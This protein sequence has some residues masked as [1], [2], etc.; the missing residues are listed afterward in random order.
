MIY[1]RI[2]PQSAL[3]DF[4]KEH[5]L[6]HF[7]YDHTKPIMVK[8]FPPI[9]E[10]GIEFFPKGLVTSFNYNTGVL[11]EEPRNAIFGQ[12]VS[13]INFTMPAEDYIMIRVIFK[14]G[15]LYRLLGIPLTSFTDIKTDA[16]CVI[17]RE[18][19]FVNEQ[20]AE[21][22][23]YQTMIE[24]VEKYL[25]VKIRKLKTCLHPVDKAG[26][27]ILADPT[28]F[29]LDW[30]SNQSCLSPRQFQ[31]KFKERMGVGPKLL[32]RIARFHGAFLYKETNPHADWLTVAV[33]FGYTDFHHLFKD[34]GEF[35][36]AT[37]NILLKQYAQSPE[38]ILKLV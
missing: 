10:H 34:F 35:A 3:Q 23:D 9:P 6:L 5:M 21:T 1:K 36:Q 38:K 15:G 20:L 22:Q 11:K 28:R 30:L 19:Q 4:V 13:R 33:R 16:E 31:R 14:P 17:N 37:P 2:K 32:S 27:L 8:P 24:I 12:Q 29:S 7:E 18:I 25:L 26:E